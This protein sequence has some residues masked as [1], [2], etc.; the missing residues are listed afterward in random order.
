M[1]QWILC[2]HHCD[3]GGVTARVGK[4]ILYS[5]RVPFMNF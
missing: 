2:L 5:L 1:L 3:M 4:E